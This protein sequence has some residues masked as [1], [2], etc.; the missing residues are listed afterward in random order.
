ML[1]FKDLEGIQPVE[2]EGHAGSNSRLPTIPD[3]AVEHGSLPTFF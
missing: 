1:C 2:G 3:P